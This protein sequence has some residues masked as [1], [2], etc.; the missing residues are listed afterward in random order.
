MDYQ[1]E[2]TAKMRGVLIDWLVEVHRRFRLL[3]ETLYLCVNLIDRFLSTANVSKSRLQLVGITAMLIACKYEEIL[4]PRV[5]DFAKIAANVYTTDQILQMERIMLSKLSF[6]ITTATTFVFL[7]R[8]LKIANADEK[9]KWIA[10]FFA[11]LSLIDIGS[12]DYK[13]SEIACAAIYLA[14]RF[15]GVVNPWVCFFVYP[16]S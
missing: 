6:S 12:L 9:M 16:M 2:I 4:V 11:E 8:Y 3:P 13:P 14:R 7:Q 10:F 5:Q 15:M 1:S